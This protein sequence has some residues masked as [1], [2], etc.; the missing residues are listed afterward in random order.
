[1]GLGPDF[2]GQTCVSSY[3]AGL[4]SNQKAVS[5]THGIHTT[6]APIGTFAKTIII[7]RHKIHNFLGLLMMPSTH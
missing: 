2:Q 3:G 5:Y 1:M 7:K 6:I 4:K